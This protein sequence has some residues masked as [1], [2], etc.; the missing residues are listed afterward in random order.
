MSRI[1][2]SHASQEKSKTP[3]EKPSYLSAAVGNEVRILEGYQEWLEILGYAEETVKSLPSQLKPFILHLNQSGITS[4]VAVPKEIIEHYYEKLKEKK[5]QQTGEL[6][7]GSTLNGHIRNLNLFSTYL[8][9][10]EQGS[11]QIHIPYE[12]KN[13]A[14]KEVLSL[15]EIEQLYHSCSEEIAGLRERAILSLYYGCGLRSKEGIN[16]NIND[17]LLDKQLI[18]IRKAK[19]SRARYVPFMEQQKQDFI[20]YLNHCRPQLIKDETQTFLVNNQGKRMSSSTVSRTLKK[21]IEQTGNEQ[22]QEKKVGLHT[23]RHSIATHLLHSG[24]SIENISQ[25]LGHSHIRSTQIY[26]HHEL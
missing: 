8:E 17:I 20:H 15:Y 22:L 21:L 19:N 4:L 6:L 14:E 11:L 26:L 18:H 16:L 7:K 2:A 5:S 23:L 13:T 25:F 10:T 9:E 24:M 1:T 12:P 3:Q